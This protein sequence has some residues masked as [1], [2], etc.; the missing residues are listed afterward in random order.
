MSGG[1]LN[2][3]YCKD[4][5]D[6]L[7]N[8]IPDMEYVEKYLI[9]EGYKDISMDVRRLIEYILTATNKNKCLS[10]QLSQVFK[11]VEW[12]ESGD[13]SKETLIKVLDK[14]REE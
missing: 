12:Y 7:L 8:E 4:E 14:Y 6:E 2:Y 1:S 11:A 13:Y 9:E 3:L 5:V 10:S